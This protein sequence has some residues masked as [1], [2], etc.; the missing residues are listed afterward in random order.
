MSSSLPVRPAGAP[1]SLDEWIAGGFRSMQPLN[2]APD[3]RRAG[4]TYGWWAGG[5]DRRWPCRT[6]GRRPGRVH[7]R[8][9]RRPDQDGPTQLRL[10]IEDSVPRLASCPPHFFNTQALLQQTPDRAALLCAGRRRPHTQHDDRHPPTQPVQCR[11]NQTSNGAADVFVCHSAPPPQG[12][13][14][15]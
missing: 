15:L 1:G 7:G 5:A 2:L 14:H 3:R 9:A 4:G 13:Y 12:F 11:P 6:T 10:A 8:N